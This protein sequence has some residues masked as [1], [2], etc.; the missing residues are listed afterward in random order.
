MHCNFSFT[1]GHANNML[2]NVPIYEFIHVLMELHITELTFRF[3]YM[4]SLCNLILPRDVTFETCHAL[5]SLW[6]C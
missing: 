2:N 4:A 5:V 3:L 6:L 1:L